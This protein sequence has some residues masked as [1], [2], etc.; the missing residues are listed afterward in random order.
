MAEPL[1][2]MYNPE[3]FEHLCSVLK[4]NIPNFDDVRFIHSVFDT[5]WP[6]LELK[7]RTRKVTKALHKTLPANYELAANCVVAIAQEYLN[8]KYEKPIYPLIFLPDYV[9]LYGLDHFEKSMDAIEQITQLVSAEFAVRPFILKYPEKT[10]N[11]M[12]RWTTHKSEHVRRLSSEGCR[13]RLPWAMGLPAFKKDPSPILPILDKLKKDPSEYVRRS[14][15]NNLNDIAKDH[16]ELVLNIARQWKNV[17]AET[18]WILKHGSRTLLKQGHSNA[19][20]FHGFD[21]Q[22]LAEVPKLSLDNLKIKIGTTGSFSFDVVNKEKKKA[23][24]RI[25]YAI[26]YRTATGKTSRKIFKVTEK[27]FQPGQKLTFER[28]QRFTDFTT[29]KHYPGQHNL[30]IIVNGKTRKDHHFHLMAK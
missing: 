21:S 8:E 29:R 2:L 17:S 26:N 10:M 14:V 12:Q 1:K 23:N 28:K 15:A 13:P 19:L 3:F 7:Q 16:P 5:E 22:L 20:D 25:E 27:E 6:D 24:L 18:N 9:E 4:K 30:E 11:R